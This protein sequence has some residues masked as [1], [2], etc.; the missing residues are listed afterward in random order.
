MQQVNIQD[1][2]EKI[3]AEG[4]LLCD[5]RLITEKA[6]VSDKE[7]II[8]KLFLQSSGSD[9]AE[10]FYCSNFRTDPASGCGSSAYCR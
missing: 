9:G 3:T 6:E 5:R 1:L 7:S 2:S 10:E 4:F 8:M